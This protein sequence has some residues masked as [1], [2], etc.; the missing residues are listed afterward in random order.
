MRLATTSLIAVLLLPAVA[1]CQDAAPSQTEEP[2]SDIRGEVLSQYRY[3]PS[4][5]KPAA[6][7]TALQSDSP[8]LPVSQQAKADVVKMEPYEVRE[9]GSSSAAYLPLERATSAK[10]PATVASKLGI[11]EHDFKVGKVHAFVITI[12]YVPFVAGFSW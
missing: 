10:P 6:M 12:F 8:P 4:G 11:G 7:P 9:S 2:G 1:Q 3:V 5:S